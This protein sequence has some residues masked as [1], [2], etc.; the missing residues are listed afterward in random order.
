MTILINYLFIIKTKN[1]HKKPVYFI[2]LLFICY[3]NSFHIKLNK[4]CL[5]YKKSSK[6][7]LI[8]DFNFSSYDISIFN[9]FLATCGLVFYFDFSSHISRYQKDSHFSPIYNRT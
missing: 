4:T 8:F 6:V 3:L 9:Y 2:D 7:N 5:G 1:Y